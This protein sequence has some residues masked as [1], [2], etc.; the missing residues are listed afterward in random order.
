[1]VT[2][3]DR[4]RAEEQYRAALRLRPDHVY[5]HYNLAMLLAQEA[6]YAESKEHLRKALRVN[7][8]WPQAQAKLASLERIQDAPV[9]KHDQ[10]AAR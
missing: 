9:E 3:V 10:R 2:P 6:R 8:N 1:V 4:P 5:A 7:P